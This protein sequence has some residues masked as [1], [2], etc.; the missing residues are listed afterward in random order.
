MI[1]YTE[2]GKPVEVTRGNFSHLVRDSQAGLQHVVFKDGT[3]EW[4]GATDKDILEAIA[5]GK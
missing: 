4:V 3:E 2:N 1:F 5:R